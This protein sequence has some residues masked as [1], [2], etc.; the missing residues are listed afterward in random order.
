[1]VMLRDPVDRLVSQY[2]YKKRL[3]GVP[4]EAM[5]ADWGDRYIPKLMDDWGPYGFPGRPCDKY[6]PAPLLFRRE[7]QNKG[8]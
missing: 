2:H 7:D 3:T 4:T 8:T 6:A 5:A 1:M